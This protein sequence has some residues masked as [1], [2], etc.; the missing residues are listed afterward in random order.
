M[1]SSQDGIFPAAENNILEDTVIDLL[2]EVLGEDENETLTVSAA[3]DRHNMSKISFQAVVQ[4]KQI[5]RND[6]LNG[7]YKVKPTMIA[8]EGRV[9]WLA[10]SHVDHFPIPFDS[11][12]DNQQ[13]YRVKVNLAKPGTIHAHRIL[14]DSDL[15]EQSDP[16]LRLTVQYR[17][18]EKD[19][20]QGSFRQWARRTLPYQH[21]G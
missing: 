19:S 11:T 18:G 5:L 13:A 6:L 10:L 16:S 14:G 8:K 17:Q 21:T 9:A 2:A 1:K 3:N 20:G 15:Y 4:P 12:S 7:T